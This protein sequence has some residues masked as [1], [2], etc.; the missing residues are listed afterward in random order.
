MKSF[1]EMTEAKVET[2]QSYR[3]V[4]LVERPKKLDPAGTSSKLVSKADKLGITT[5]N[6]RINGAYLIRDEDTGMVTIHNEGDEKGFELDADTIVFI[7]GDVTKKD[8][9][10]DLISQIERYG[11]ACNNTRET[12]EVCC[13]KFRTYLRLQEIGMNQPKTVLIPNDTPEA[14]DAAHEALDNK[15]PMVLKTLSGSKGVG[16]LLIETER[17]LQ[18]QVSLIYKIDPY[19][20]ILLQEYIES[21]YDV[22]CVIVNKE[23]VGAMKRNKITDDFRSNA[24]Q[25]ATVELITLTELEKQECL[26]AAKGVNGQWCGVDFIPADNRD[27]DVPYILEVNHSAGSKAISEALEEDITK[28]VLKLYFDRDMWRK[29]P[30]QCGVLETFEVDGAVLT[31]KLDT[32]NST[33]VCSLHADDVEVK[34]KKV[35]WTMNGEKHSKPLH[36]TIE[37]IKPAESRPVVMMDVEFLNT[38]YEVEV[39]LDKRNQIPFLVNRDFMQRANLMINPARKFMLTNKSEDGIG[40]I[41]K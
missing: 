31:G 32:G 13:D 9:Y 33:S 25:G 27:K 18:S 40:D 37:L 12:I 16:V 38:T 6:C 4:V 26:K 28:M 15:F 14:V 2:K 35:T 29:E 41:Q 23:I 20:D 7:R 10:M 30:K 36:R 39:S 34:G 17:S 3:L 24:S 11:I 5:Y 21:D 19:T 22:R 1:S 8:S